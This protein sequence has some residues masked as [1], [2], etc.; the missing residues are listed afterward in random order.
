MEIEALN[1]DVLIYAGCTKG[2]SSGLP[3]NQG[4]ML[5]APESAETG[6]IAL[7]ANILGTLRLTD[8]ADVPSIP[9]SPGFILLRIASQRHLD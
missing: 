2:G 5:S 3:M 1:P 4:C 7:K 8:R 6:C 9:V